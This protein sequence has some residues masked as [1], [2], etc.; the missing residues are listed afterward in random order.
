MA[1]EVPS[2]MA[3]TGEQIEEGAF[4][5]LVADVARSG[6]AATSQA[7]MAQ[8]EPLS[9]QAV[10]FATRPMEKDTTEVLLVDR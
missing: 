1:R 3:S 8:P 6:A 5:A 9:A 4:G 7:K 2:V 10:V